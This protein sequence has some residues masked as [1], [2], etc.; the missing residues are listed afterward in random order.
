MKHNGDAA[1]PI[2]MDKLLEFYAQWKDRTYVEP[3]QSPF[4]L[5]TEAGV[6]VE[7]EE[8]ESTNSDGD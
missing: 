6:I 8:N 2:K 1:I 7:M 3:G 4:V 5:A